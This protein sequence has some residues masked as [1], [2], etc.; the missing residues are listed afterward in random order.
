[1]IPNKHSFSI[2]N[3]VNPATGKPFGSKYAGQFAV[4]RPNFAD[5]RAIALRDAAALSA[6]GPVDQRHLSLDV[7]NINFIFANLDVIAEKKPDWCDIS[8]LYDETDEQAIYTVWQEV[9]KFLDSF[10]PKADPEACGE[11][12]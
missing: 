12:R 10:R 3:T 5:N 7:V 11:P 6:Y 8:K 2:E 1:M 9:K 4:R